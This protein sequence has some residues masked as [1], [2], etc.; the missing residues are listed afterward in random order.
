MSI[1]ELKHLLA[2]AE[3]DITIKNKKIVSLEDYI[4]QLEEKLNAVDPEFIE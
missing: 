4:L 2:V 3:K 1:K